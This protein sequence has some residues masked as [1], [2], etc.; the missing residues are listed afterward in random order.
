MTGGPGCSSLVALFNENG[1]Y[2]IQD[3]LSLKLNPYSWNARANILFIDQPVNTGFSYSD[4][5]DIGVV[6]EAEMAQD[7]WEFFQNF[8]KQ[9]PKYANLPFYVSND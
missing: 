6:T 1:P 7:M 5:G 3:D 2:I 8:F 4:F 9:Y